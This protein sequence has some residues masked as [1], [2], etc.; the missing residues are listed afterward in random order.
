MQS[1]PIFADADVG[2][3]N[4]L[5]NI[6]AR[7]TLDLVPYAPADKTGKNASAVSIY[8]DRNPMSQIQQWNIN[9]QRQVA[10]VMVEV[11][12]AGS[13]G[14]H[15]Q[16]GAFNL[17]AIPLD[18]AP[19]AQ[20]RFIAPYVSYPQYPSGVNVQ[21]WIGSS[22]YN[23]LQM[24]AEKRFASGLGFLAAFTFQKLI[25]VGEQGWRNPLGNRNLDRGISP[26]SA[27][28][29]FTIG[30][31]YALPF[32][33]GRR[34]L[35]GGIAAAA[36]GGWELNGITTFQAGF[37]L[38][39]GLNINSCVCG[40]NLNLP[41]VLRNPNLP[42]EERTT[43]RWFDTGALAAP[44]Q[45]TVGN[46][47]RGMIWGPGLNNFD[48]EIGKMF[49]LSRLREGANLGFRG[50]F[51]NIANTPYFDNPNVTFGATTVGRITGVS[52]S[53]RQAQLALK[54]M[55]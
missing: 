9:I 19:V 42:K 22:N 46:A 38:T 23:S 54:L 1:D 3:Y 30:Y 55:W 32:G 39:P 28:Y 5:D 52:N 27:P 2:R 44:S 26:D 18:L 34:W 17:N 14:T 12:Y 50:E 51:Y 11:G 10:S 41:D 31:N 49:H 4:T 7:T 33:T 40:N 25:N 43:Q 47:G 29:R 20:G 53:P 8:P 13:K 16:Y 35:N 21:A 45:Y 15:L 48:L 36:L 24:K 37:P 6:H